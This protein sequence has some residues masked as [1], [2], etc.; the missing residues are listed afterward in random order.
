LLAASLRARSRVAFQ[1]FCFFRRIANSGLAPS[2]GKKM[3][4]F[5]KAFCKSNLDLLQPENVFGIGAT[6]PFLALDGKFFTNSTV[7]ETKNG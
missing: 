6:F 4:R 5:S 3:I 7:R 1:I 2:P